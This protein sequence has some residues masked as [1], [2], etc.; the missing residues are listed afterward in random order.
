ME[1]ESTRTESC[2]VNVVSVW[3]KRE[4]TEVLSI[5]ESIGAVTMFRSISLA[6]DSL[7]NSSFIELGSIGR[8]L[9]SE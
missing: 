8:E 3:F 9:L 2:M 5:V 4:S 1:L 7:A 6:G